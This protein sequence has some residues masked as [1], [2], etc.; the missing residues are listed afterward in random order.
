MARL[1]AASA[2]PV[3]G[4]VKRT[5][6]LKVTVSW[7]SARSRRTPPAETDASCWSSPIRRTLAPRARA[8]A[9]R[10][11]RSA[12][13]AMPASSTM[14]RVSE[15][16][17]SNHR[18]AGSSAGAGVAVLVSVSWLSLAM[19]SVGEARSWA[20]TSAAPAVGARPM[21]VPPLLRQAAATAAMAVVLPVPAGASASWRRAPEVAMS[22][23]RA[24]CP[25]LSVRP[26][27]AWVSARAKP[28]LM[29]ST[30]RPSR[31]VAAARMRRS[32]AMMAA[33]V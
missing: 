23:T 31:V 24:T 18:R 5:T 4:W 11:S 13:E 25:W 8:W 15:L 9:M 7:R 1:A 33:L 20:R 21:T 26:W 6:V 10:V 12:V 32:A 30:V 19:V 16:M 3:S 22:R 17:R 14:S 29:S 27:L 2:F 28:M